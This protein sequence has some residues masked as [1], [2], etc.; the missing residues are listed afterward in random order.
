MQRIG[1]EENIGDRRARRRP[2]E[3]E[4]GAVDAKTTRTRAVQAAVFE[5]TVDEKQ[6]EQ[7]E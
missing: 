5:N 3:I 2:V 4:H 6:D 1:K 7:L